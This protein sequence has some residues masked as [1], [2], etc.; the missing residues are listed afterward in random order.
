MMAVA[1]HSPGQKAAMFQRVV[2]GW[3]WLTI[4]L[5][6]AL[7]VYVVAMWR[8]ALPSFDVV[9]YHDF[10]ARAAEGRVQ[11]ETVWQR[12]NGVHLIVLP[13]LLWVLDIWLVAGQG[14]LVTAVSACVLAATL[15]LIVRQVNALPE[16]TH[17]EKQLFGMLAALVLSSVLMAECLLS[18]VNSQWSL[19]AFGVVVMAAG[20][21][22]A[23]VQVRRVGYV[24]LFAGALLAYLSSAPLTVLLLALLLPLLIALQSDGLPVHRYA[25]LLFVLL[26]TACIAWEVFAW[27]SGQPLLLALFYQQLVSPDKVAAVEPFIRSSESIYPQWLMSRLVFMGQYLLLTL[28]KHWQPGWWLTLVFGIWCVGVLRSMVHWRRQHLF[29]T[30]LL[31][32]ALV[33]GVGAALLRFTTLYDYR[34][35]NI[36]FLLGFASLVLVF[37]SMN[38]RYRQIG[39]QVAL[40]VYSP[41]F[42]FAMAQ[43]AGA[44]AWEGRN[45]I[46]EQQI[47][48]AVGVKDPAMFAYV[49]KH[50]D[51]HVAA[52]EADRAVFRDK[53]IGIYASAGYRLMVGEIALPAVLQQCE[54]A[55]AQVRQHYPDPQA[56]LVRGSTVAADG[57]V[58]TNVLFLDIHGKGIGWALAQLP[59]DRL[60]DQLLMP[61]SW[62]GHLRFADEDAAD[63]YAADQQAVDVI[64]FNDKK[65]CQPYRLTLP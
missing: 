23:C 21:Q 28:G 20:L 25:L 37:F 58:M 18:P 57:D 13:R 42:L 5:S 17:G 19:L 15:W 3:L 27:F 53:R 45:Q 46:R 65:R 38:G 41:I 51:E 39:L 2:L 7:T 43:E 12:H 49:W 64:A 50:D 31:V 4:L 55:V 54:Y 34:H 1:S 56:F 10:L 48:A 16:L 11:W 44:W 9:D 62:G 47:G 60:L 26:L 36:G 35:A 40:L 63:Q 52:V 8:I 14:W 30:C 32:F 61:A 33:M 24:W 6:V 59:S 22:L 29:L